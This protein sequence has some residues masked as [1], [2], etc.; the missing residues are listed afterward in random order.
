[1]YIRCS[2]LQTAEKARRKRC[3]LCGPFTALDFVPS[4][5]MQ[6]EAR[7]RYCTYELL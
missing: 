1:M 7:F 2:V 6:F 4:P 5:S 3:L